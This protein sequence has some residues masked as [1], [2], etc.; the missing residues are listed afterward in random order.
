MG[1]LALPRTSGRAALRG[2]TVE[3]L[4][5]RA[6]RCLQD[7]TVIGCRTK[8]LNFASCVHRV[9]L[10]KE[11]PLIIRHVAVYRV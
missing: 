8:E 4:L 5:S 9:G 1:A 6:G 11:H 3:A 10:K 7:R 2:A